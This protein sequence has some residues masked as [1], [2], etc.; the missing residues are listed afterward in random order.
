M[1]EAADADVVEHARRDLRDLL[2]VAAL[3]HVVR[4]RRLPRATPVYTVGHMARV[5][6]MRERA[7]SLGA[8]G[9]AGNAYGGVGIPDCIRSGED[10]ARD[11]LRVLADRGIGPWAR[12]S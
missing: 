11:V 3:P 6:G 8:L 5:D 10:A 12:A 4:I 1:S 2:G 9:L 7:R